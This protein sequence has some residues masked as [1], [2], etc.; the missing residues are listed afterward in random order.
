MYRCLG[1]LITFH[2]LLF[3]NSIRAILSEYQLDA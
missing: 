1:Y 3:T 2:E